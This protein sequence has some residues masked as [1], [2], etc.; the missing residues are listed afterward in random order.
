MSAQLRALL[1]SSLTLRPVE[2]ISASNLSSSTYK[3]KSFGTVVI[4]RSY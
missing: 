3:W 1:T 4:T 2:F